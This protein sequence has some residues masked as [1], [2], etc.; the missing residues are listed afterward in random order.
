MAPVATE[1]EKIINT[2][3]ER[4]KNEALADKIFSRGRRQSAPTNSK[5]QIGGS[6]ASRVGVKKSQPQNK[7]VTATS[8]RRRRA[9]VPAGD[10]NGEWTHDLHSTVNRPNSSAN[11]PLSSRITLPGGAAANSAA[12][13]AA[14]KKKVARLTAAFDRMETD[15]SVKRQVNIVKNGK[16]QARDTG[17][18]IR[19][20]A[21]PFAVM[22]QNFAPGTTAADIESAMTPVGGEM[23]SCEIVKTQ[24][25]I[26]VE[27]V[28]ASREGGEKVIETFNN[29][30]ADGRIIKVYPKPGGYKANRNSPFSGRQKTSQDDDLIVDYNNDLMDR[31]NVPPS[32]RGG[33]NRLQY[34]NDGN[35][36]NNINKRGRGFQKGSNNG[37]R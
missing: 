30:T 34:N 1:F 3:R 26:I 22:A 27:M 21:G 17:M 36:N 33:S 10:V 23:V 8:S 6:L 18:T 2:A 35:K 19:G 29:K 5:P 15:D 16:S 20:L 32:S 13:K 25:F 4:K 7:A 31:E 12:K 28:F 9:S 24:P 37:G 14:A 11:A